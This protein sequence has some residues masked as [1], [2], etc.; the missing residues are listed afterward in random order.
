MINHLKLNK[1]FIIPSIALLG[2]FSSYIYA[3][4][5]ISI[6]SFKAA[7]EN[8]DSKEAITYMDFEAIRKSLKQ[9]LK[10]IVN[11]SIV[12]NMDD[13]RY[14]S[15]TMLLINPI[16]NS[17]IESALHATI[18]P[19]G[20]N[21]LLNYGEFTSPRK[22]TNSLQQN[23]IKTVENKKMSKKQ[24]QRKFSLYYV[25]INEFILKTSDPKEKEIIKAYWRRYG[26]TSWKLY[27]VQIPRNLLEKLL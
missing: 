25:G 9:Q 16:A 23:L 21:N 3:T 24:E 13:K 7:I 26:I 20:I 4:P 18:S 27:S 14:S 5:Y 2:I 11:K 10:I 6:L 19:Y 22:N 8:K 15:V 1:I 12:K 17:L